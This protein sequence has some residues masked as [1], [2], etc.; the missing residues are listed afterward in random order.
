MQAWLR[1]SWRELAALALITGLAAVLRFWQLAAIPPGFHYDEAYEAL[2]AWRVLH[3]ADYRPIFFPGNFGV[4]PMFIYLTSLAFRLFGESPAAMRGV[5][6]LIGTLTVPALY[7]LGRELARVDRRFSVSAAWLAAIALATMRWHI[8]FSRVGIEPILVPFFLV[9]ILWTFWRACR[10]GRR[11][12]WVALGIA[13]GLSPYTYPAGRLLTVLVAFLCLGALVWHW[14][15]ARRTGVPS[16][17]LAN[18]LVA[19]GIAL[20]IVAPLAWN[21]IQH[22]DQLLLRSRQIAVG[23]GGAAPGTPAE[24]V[25]ATLGMFSVRGDRDP[26]SNVPGMPAFDLL[27]SIPFMVGLG[28]AVW[29]WKRGV[30]AGLLLAAAIMLAPTVFSE[31]APH[32]R[33][34]VGVTPVAALLVGMGLALILGR[35]QEGAAADAYVPGQLRESGWEPE[36]L[37]ARM[38]RLRWWG[39]V[40]VVAAILIGS[41]IYSAIAYFD[42]WGGG[43]VLYYAYDQGLWEI[44]EY[45]RSLPEDEPVYLSPRPQ[46]DMTLAFAWRARR[47]VR[48]FD[49]RH[50][51]VAPAIDRPATFIFIRHED[52]RGPMVL[53]DLYPEAQETKTFHDRAGRLYARAFRVTEPSLIARRPQVAAGAKWP[54]LTLEG[55]DIDR[56]TFEPGKKMFLQLWWR[57]DAPQHTDWT[58]FTHVLGPPKPDGNRVWAGLDSAPGQGSVPTRTWAVGDLILDEYQIPLP[59]ETPPGSYQIEI[60]LYDP[61]M[62]ARRLALTEPAGQDYLILGTVQVK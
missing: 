11:M 43:N 29:R 58:V 7:F 40:T 5:A 57:A 49:G 30:F 33:R 34:A 16:R 15:S 4:E 17:M 10:T 47:G 45:V 39:R 51:F 41:A 48:R 9:L 19:G 42:I 26:R 59:G 31:H 61:T 22:P 27:L 28:L 2:E 1:R 38:D 21:W 53:R 23:P 18:I 13:T 14:V 55:Y 24:G 52:Y 50:A 12:A 56:H 36:E 44:G 8:T 25:L 46:T 6:A 32:F 60:G 35:P 3:Q 20:L 37:S 62:N 54:G